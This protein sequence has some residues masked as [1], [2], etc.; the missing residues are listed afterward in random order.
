M[1]LSSKRPFTKR[2][3][4]PVDN[5]LIVI[6][7]CHI[8]DESSLTVHLGLIPFQPPW[9]K[10]KTTIRLFFLKQF[11][12]DSPSDRSHFTAARH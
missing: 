6:E 7:L 4:I 1:T 3:H 10:S 2:S 11:C 12:L 8:E 9:T 5:D